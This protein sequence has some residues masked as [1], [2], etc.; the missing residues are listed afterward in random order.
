MKSSIC[1]AVFIIVVQAG[2]ADR[3]G[4]RRKPAGGSADP[5][6]DDVKKFCADASAK[7]SE[8]VQGCLKAHTDQLSKACKSKLQGKKCGGRPRDVLKEAMEKVV[9][10]CQSESGL[11]CPRKKDSALIGCLTSH[12]AAAT[13]A[14]SEALDE[15]RKL[16]K[17]RECR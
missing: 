3:P 11:L 16:K 7:G 14:C 10:A 1:A 9:S 4:A 13:A 2:A 17:K 5:C 12:A 8:A 15:L 6:A